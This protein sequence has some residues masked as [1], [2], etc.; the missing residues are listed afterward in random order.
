MYTFL[1]VCLLAA[2]IAVWV[3]GR[4]N[5][6]LLPVGYALPAV[7]LGM[8]LFRGCWGGRDAAVPPARVQANM[9]AHLGEQ[10]GVEAA[11]LIPERGAV[12]VIHP[13]PGAPAY[14]RARVRHMIQG[15]EKGLNPRGFALH[16]MEMNESNAAGDPL[17]DGSYIGPQT[18]L[19]LSGEVD[20]PV[21][22]VLLGLQIGTASPAEMA[23]VPPLVLT[24]T[25]DPGSS[26]WALER[27]HALVAVFEREGA[28]TH[29]NRAPVS[30]RVES[31]YEMRVPAR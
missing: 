5:P 2:S 12:V 31:R 8:L 26:E 29:D 27:G 3:F 22:V 16:P 25:G 23:A 4:S 7:A 14:A 9:A 19:R 30:A 24:D 28:S 20:A 10:L 15:L 6:K 13:S 17:A 18:I 21:A 1:L 11:N